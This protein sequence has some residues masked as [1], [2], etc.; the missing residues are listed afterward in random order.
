MNV[1]KEEFLKN[2]KRRAEHLRPFDWFT[3]DKKIKLPQIKIDLEE[4][5][6]LIFEK[7]GQE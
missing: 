4:D 7:N 3:S 5:I 2:I 6:K 1:T